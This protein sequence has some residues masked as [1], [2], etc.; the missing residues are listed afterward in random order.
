MDFSESR[1]KLSFFAK[2]SDS[3]FLV[4]VYVTGWRSEGYIIIIGM[5][6]G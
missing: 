4:A 1:G 5:D 3:T 2:P 6:H